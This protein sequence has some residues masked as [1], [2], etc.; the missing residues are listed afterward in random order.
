MSSKL[1]KILLAALLIVFLGL[2]LY[3]ALTDSQ[4]IDEGPHIAGGYSYWLTGDYRINP[5]H[6]P[7][8]KLLATLPLLFYGPT[9]PV[10]SDS[11][12]H[13]N[14]WEFGRQFLYN[15]IKPADTIIFLARLFPVLLGL[16]LGYYIYR[17]AK[18]LFGPKAGLFALFLFVFSPDFLGHSHLVTTDVPLSLFFLLSIYYFGRYIKK[19]SRKNLWIGAIV[20]ALA[21]LTKYSALILIPVLALLYLINWRL[22]KNTNKLGLKKFVKLFL[23]YLATTVVLTLVVYG[24]EFKKPLTDP[25]VGRLYE[26]RAEI[27]SKGQEKNQMFFVKPL[28]S[29]ADPEKPTGRFIYQLAEKFPVPAYSYW[30]G[31]FNVL[32]HNLRGHGSYLFGQYSLTGW[33]Y[34]F[35]IAF[36][37]KNPLPILILSLVTFFVFLYKYIISRPASINII[38]ASRFKE[39]TQSYYLIIVPPL[40][41]FL[42]SL[43]SHLNLGIRHIFP[44]YPFVFLG[45]AALVNLKI[46]NVF[47]RLIYKVFLGAIVLYYLL[48]NIQIFPFYISYFNELV[49]GPSQGQNYLLDSNIDWGQDIKRLKKYL[50]TNNIEKCY[51]L[52]FGSLVTNY[53]IKG[54]MAMPDNKSVEKFGIPKGYYVISTFPLFD[55]TWSFSWLIKY[56]PVKRIGYSIYV[57]NF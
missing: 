47:S 4:T 44:V 14:E 5:E 33:W 36:I 24:F 30:R 42:W 13:Y 57:Y 2:S 43:T 31:F 40:V 21:I 41:F 35:I 7:L 20:F 48:T 50:D 37:I 28:L 15:N 16:I 45:L 8:I 34:Y 29:L 10:N 17:W 51:S 46:I 11:W 32:S 12:R 23:V 26:E 55:P 1:E 6:P 38:R 39:F 27:I 19:P 3:L 49:G 52:L 18:E 9:L 56:P 25:R 53:Y 54:E 22:N